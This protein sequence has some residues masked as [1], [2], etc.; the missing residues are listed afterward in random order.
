MA[1]VTPAD[2]NGGV[3]VSYRCSAG[4]RFRLEQVHAA[5]SD[6]AGYPPRSMV[7]AV[8]FD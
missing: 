3:Y 8:F 1:F 6:R 5:G 4:L 2:A 7:S